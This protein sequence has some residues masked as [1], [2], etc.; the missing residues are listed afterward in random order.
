MRGYLIVNYTHLCIFF[1]VCIVYLL[2]SPYSSLCIF[3]TLWHLWIHSILSLFMWLL[4]LKLTG[5]SWSS[6]LWKGRTRDRLGN[7]AGAAW[8]SVFPYHSALQKGSSLHSTHCSLTY[9]HHNPLQSGTK[10]GLHRMNMAYLFG[11]VTIIFFSLTLAGSH[12]LLL[13]RCAD[14]FA[15]H[16]RYPLEG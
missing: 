5:S 6:Y 12:R 3:F 7:W 15:R 14:M 10:H 4:I 9:F 13:R 11:L 2:F 16:L 8:I 1:L